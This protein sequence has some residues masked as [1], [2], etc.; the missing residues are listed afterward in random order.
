[1]SALS[2]FINRQTIKIEYRLTDS[3]IKKIGA[4]DK[5]AVNP[6]FRTGPPMLLYERGRVKKW[7][8]ENQDIIH[9]SRKR[10]VPAPPSAATKTKKTRHQVES[11]DFDVPVMEKDLLMEKACAHYNSLWN[12]RGTCNKC[13]SKDDD[14]EFIK[15][16]CINY[17]RHQVSGYENDRED[18]RGRTG[19]RKGYEIIKDEVMEAIRDKYSWLFY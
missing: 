6:H 10:K 1:M 2:D 11:A 16:I 8:E 18:M 7:I 3:L 5:T 14:P 12:A 13:A 19:T 9:R 4:P 17:L 15:R